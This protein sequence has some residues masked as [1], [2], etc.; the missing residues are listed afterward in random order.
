MPQENNLPAN[1]APSS[2]VPQRVLQV[3]KHIFVPVIMTDLIGGK[4]FLHRL[5]QR[6]ANFLRVLLETGSMDSAAEEIGI[7]PD[8]GARFA[9]RLHI[10]KYLHDMLE[11]KALAMGLTVEKLLA[12]LNLQ[13]DGEAELTD[14]QM[15]AI[16]TAARILKPN[17]PSVNLTVNS[18]VNNVTVDPYSKL[19][20]KEL[21][22]GIRGALIAAD[23]AKLIPRD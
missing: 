18:Q 6:E 4:K 15:E 8:R 1:T 11:Q 13:V 12:K 23:D 17:I 10:Q 5:S 14:K 22:E 3:G 2:I 9:R 19:S 20:G 7:S 21:I 16:K